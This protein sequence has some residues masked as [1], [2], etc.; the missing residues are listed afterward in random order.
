MYEIKQL[1]MELHGFD[2]EKRRKAV[3]KLGI[4]GGTE[5]LKALHLMMLS[6]HEDEI[7]RGKAALM[8][9]KLADLSSVPYLIRALGS[10]DHTTPINAA[11]AL[12]KIGDSRAIGPLN[13]IYQN[14]PVEDEFKKA[15][16]NALEK[17][18]V[19][20]SA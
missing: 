18:G 8:L 6:D 3:L 12:G 1:L 9:A 20:V 10:K 16:A 15:I 13:N 14:Y 5:A 17:L 11:F 7:A 19:T 4:I 2:K